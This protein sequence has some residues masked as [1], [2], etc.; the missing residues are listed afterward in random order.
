M[1]K[2]KR[3]TARRQDFGPSNLGIVPV[4]YN[5]D[6][7]DHPHDS[8]AVSGNSIR[9]LKENDGLRKNGDQNIS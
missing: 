2:V 1:E 7:G 3:E 9:H 5:A 6:I 4:N 8:D